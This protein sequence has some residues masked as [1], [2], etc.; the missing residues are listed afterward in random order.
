[1]YFFLSRVI[2]CKLA[3]SNSRFFLTKKY[4]YSMNEIDVLRY[5][6]CLIENKSKSLKKNPLPINGLRPTDLIRFAQIYRAPKRRDCYEH[7]INNITSPS[8]KLNEKSL[9][10]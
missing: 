8:L 9:M 3:H 1:M 4:A 6:G 7:R 5:D 2:I 10:T